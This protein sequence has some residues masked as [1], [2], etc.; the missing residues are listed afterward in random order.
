MKIKRVLLVAMALLICVF[1]FNVQA[2]AMS[3]LFEKEYSELG[4]RGTNGFLLN[5]VNDSDTCNLGVSINAGSSTKTYQVTGTQSGVVT[6][7]MHNIST[8][9][10]YYVSLNS[11]YHAGELM[12]VSI[13][14]GNYTVTVVSNSCGYIFSIN[15]TFF[16]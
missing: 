1:T 2:F 3:D 14:T 13:P 5:S 8:G 6:I 11:G 9:Y 12:G 16:H 10:N 4:D 7:K 15:C